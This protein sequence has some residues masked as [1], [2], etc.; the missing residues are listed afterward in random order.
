MIG[1]LDPAL[2]LPRGANSTGEQQL[3]QEVDEIVRIC[4]DHRIELPALDEYWDELWGGL[5]RALQRTLVDHRAQRALDELRRLGRPPT[6]RPLD[7]WCGRVYGFRQLFCDLGEAGDWTDRMTRAV[8]R[9]TLVGR[10]TVLLVRR[11]L[12]RNLERH[13]SAES[14]IEEPTR[15]VVQLHVRGAAPRV[16]PCVHHRRNLVDDLRWTTRFDWRL[17][18]QADGARYPFCPPTHWWKRRVEAVRTMESRPVWLDRL[19]GGWARPNIRGGSGYH[20]D[21]Y[22]TDAE[23]AERIGLTQLNIVEFGAPAAQGR[24]GFIHHLPGK[25]KARLRDDTGWSCP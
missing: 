6:M 16:V 7:P 10:P 20:W 4:R 25:K 5:G 11:M 17:P 3:T 1:L 21:V 23:L 2:L 14:V 24:P 9:A 12:G 18:G 15:W 8:L 19:G 22:I 13:A